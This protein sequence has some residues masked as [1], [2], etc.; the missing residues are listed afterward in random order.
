MVLLSLYLNAD[1]LYSADGAVE[2]V[3]DEREKCT[4][5]C[6]ICAALHVRAEYKENYSTANSSDRPWSLRS[7]ASISSQLFLVWIAARFCRTQRLGMK[8]PSPGYM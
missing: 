4:R 8:T 5:S 7:S 1:F 6:T 3:E 2:V